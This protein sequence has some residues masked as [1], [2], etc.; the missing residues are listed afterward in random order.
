MG[1]NRSGQPCKLSL[2][3]NRIQTFVGG[4]S[5]T[6]RRVEPSKTEGIEGYP[7]IGTRGAIPNQTT[8]SQS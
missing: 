2:V 1:F 6:G 8:D 3:S 7:E 5:N 4:S